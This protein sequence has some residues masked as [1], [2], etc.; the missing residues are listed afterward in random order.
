MKA[1]LISAPCLSNTLILENKIVINKH[2]KEIM[3]RSISINLSFKVRKV[4]EQ[5]K[6]VCNSQ[7]M[8]EVGK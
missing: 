1:N 3:N 6:I 4:A 5:V 8:G 7:T 2:R